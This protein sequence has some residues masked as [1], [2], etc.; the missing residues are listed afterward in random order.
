MNPWK[1]LWI[2]EEISWGILGD[3]F[4]GIFREIN[5][6]ILKEVAEF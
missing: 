2:L 4:G 1:I 5:Y 6:A 3:I